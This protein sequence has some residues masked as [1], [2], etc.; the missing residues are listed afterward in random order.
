MSETLLVVESPSKARTISKY[1]GAGFSVKASMGHI[2]DLPSN[3]IA[4]E[5]EKDFQPSFVILPAKKKTV[6]EL[7]TAANKSKNILLAADPDREGEAICYHLAE[8]FKETEKPVKRILFY[9]ITSKSV[10]EALSSPVDIDPCKVEAQIARRIVDRLVGY[11]ISPLLWEKVKP[12]LSAGRVQTVAL[13]MLSEREAEIEAFVPQE[14]W[15][16]GALVQGDEKKP[17]ECKLSHFKGKK[18]EVKNKEQNDEIVESLKGK[19][20]RVHSLIQKE[21]KKSPP[22]PYT[23]SKLQQEASRLLRFPVKKTMSVAQRLYEG[24]DLAKGETTGL[25]TYM[26]T[27]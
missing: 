15:V 19:E 3:K 4:V 5:V 8:I 9:E 13:R 18:A 10:K 21:V 20:W 25:I 22:P 6:K 26:R 16:I 11:Y 24:V 1:L 7:L 27:D 23:T 2:R 17:F 12:R 14:Y